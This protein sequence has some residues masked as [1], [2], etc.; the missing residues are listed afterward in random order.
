MAAEQSS[1][2]ERSSTPEQ[3]NAAKRVRLNMR[4]KKIFCREKQKNEPDLKNIKSK[5]SRDEVKQKDKFKV[6]ARVE[7]NHSLLNMWYKK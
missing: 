3:C 4:L 7:K 5:Q 6:K 2:P 1:D